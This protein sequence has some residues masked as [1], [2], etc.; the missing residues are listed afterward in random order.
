MYEFIEEITHFW[1]QSIVL[2]DSDLTTT[3]APSLWRRLSDAG[4]RINFDREALTVN[5]YTLNYIITHLFNFFSFA[6][7]P[8]YISVGSGNLE[9]RHSV[10]IKALS[11]AISRRI[12]ALR[13]EWWN[14]TLCFPEI[15]IHILY[16]NIY[17]MQSIY[18]HKHRNRQKKKKY[19]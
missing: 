8:T 2:V 17:I 12:L 11:L 7:Y 16:D 14:L 19:M 6:L 3:V 1:H 5:N 4:C 10:L 13:V 18:I 15:N 9:L